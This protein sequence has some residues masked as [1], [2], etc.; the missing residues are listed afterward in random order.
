MP[1]YIA[2]AQT[3]YP[4]WIDPTVQAA[5]SCASMFACFGPMSS[6]AQGMMQL[7]GTAAGQAGAP[8]GRHRA[9]LQSS[10]GLINATTGSIVADLVSSPGQTPYQQELQSALTMAQA[11]VASSLTDQNGSPIL[12]SQVRAARGGLP[13]RGTRADC[14]TPLSPA[15]PQV[16]VGISSHSLQFTTWLAGIPFTAWTPSV[17][18][19]F[20]NGINADT[21]PAISNVRT[22]PARPAQR[23]AALDAA[24]SRQGT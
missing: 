4:A 11:S 20:I 7:S 9:L 16:T 18:A 3:Y 17:Q 5:L 1:P 6:A 14:A 2:C 15:T 23:N 12:P 21:L 8:S 22:P 19:A 10:G 24:G 13:L